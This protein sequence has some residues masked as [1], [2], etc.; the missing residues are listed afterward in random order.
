M[1]VTFDK[2]SPKKN[3]ISLSYL[4]RNKKTL[5]VLLLL[6]LSLPLTYRLGQKAVEL[7]ISAT[8]KPASLV[9]SVDRPL[10]PIRP[11]WNGV[12]QG[13]EESEQRLDKSAPYLRG[14]GIK[15]VRID[16]LYDGFG[17]VSRQ[18]G[19]L[20]YDWSKLDLLVGDIVAAG[21][22]PFFSLSYMP[23]EIS[24]GDILDLPRDW[25]EWGQ[26][27]AATVA[28]YSRDYKGGLNNVIYEVW[29]EPDLF[30]GWK[31]YGEK[32]YT[33][34]YITASRAAAAVPGTKPFKIGGPA[35]TG[36]YPAWV[37]GFYKKLDEQVRIDFFSWHRY[38]AD[39]D[40]FI[41][42]A[43]SARAQIAPE[44]TRPQDLY[45]SEWGVNAERG[46]A[47]DSR[48]AGAHFLAV[49]T[50]LEDTAIDMALAFEVQD[51]VQADTQFHGGWGMLTNPKFGPVLKKP[52]FRALEMV[53]KLT[54][55]KLTVAGQ[56]SFVTG[57]AAMDSSGTTRVLAVNYDKNG[58]HQ[59]VFPLTLAGLSNA[60]YLVT[61]ETL[62]GRIVKNELVPTEGI[63]R[64]EIA[65][66]PSDAVLVT[67]SKK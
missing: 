51:G 58:R 8:Y 18:D 37:D 1:P 54:G 46:S 26:V 36:Y 23:P 24:R 31:M 56:G 19:R 29:N 30:G 4:I 45:I 50:A 41:K 3:I 48:W 67:V 53:S 59:E 16:H 32:N 62:S 21:A 9:V 34:M 12:A 35:T 65:L 10:R 43:E 49:I 2:S 44:I 57:L 27:I 25:G 13:H 38:S 63:L 11:I 42:D 40:D 52:R 28:R 39:V 15:Y 6:I 64:R 47:Y 33:T 55:D 61:E 17:V 7:F 66:S 5:F 20:S 22:V 14:A 60:S